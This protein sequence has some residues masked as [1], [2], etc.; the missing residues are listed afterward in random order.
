MLPKACG[1][2]ANAF[3]S[4]NSQIAD[5]MIKMLRIFYDR[6]RSG[7]RVLSES[8]Y[9]E[10]LLNFEVQEGQ[11]TRAEDR[12]KAAFERAW[13]IRNFEIELYWKRATYFWA[14]IASAFVGFFALTVSSNYKAHD[15]FDHA[16]VFFI[17]CIGFI[18]S[19]AWLLTNKGSKA[20]QRHWE[21]H[22]DMLEDAFTGP[23]YKTVHPR[24]TYSVSKINEIVSFVIVIVWLLLGTKY[25]FDQNLV[26]LHPDR[27]NWFVVIASIGTALAIMSMTLGYGRGRFS[28][29]E[30]VFHRRDVQYQKSPSD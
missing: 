12:A 23:L 19:N 27:I 17:A 16:E 24:L 8:E 10:A 21:V 22:V 25:L 7:L 14:F 26:N 2:T 6:R 15:E 4:T 18:L 13:A 29:R 5:L 11:T 20:W 3:T 1:L 28:S 9:K 30:V